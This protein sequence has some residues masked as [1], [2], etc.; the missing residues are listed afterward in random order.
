MA[1]LLRKGTYVRVTMYDINGTGRL[2][3]IVTG[4]L[5]SD[6]AT[7]ENGDPVLTLATRSGTE[8]LPRS[9][10]YIGLIERSIHTFSGR[11]NRDAGAVRS[12][13]SSEDT[14]YAFSEAASNVWSSS[15]AS[16]DRTSQAPSTQSSTRGRFKQPRVV[17]QTLQ[18]GWVVKVT[19]RHH[20]DDTA[21]AVIVSGRV[22]EVV[23][24]RKPIIKLLR[25]D[26]S[27]VLVPREQFL[28]SNI[29]LSDLE[30]FNVV[31]AGRSFK[32][33]QPLLRKS[34]GMSEVGGGSFVRMS[35]SRTNR[36][37]SGDRQTSLSSNHS[38]LDYIQK[39]NSMKLQLDNLCTALESSFNSVGTFNRGN[40][41]V[42]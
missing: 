3:T 14:R 41:S 2:P 40:V 10:L 37:S 9:R 31:G 18:P 24:M 33:D 29:D 13:T 34:P 5:T 20:S 35:R 23:D 42:T 36:K 22:I 30:G 26:G 15:Y 21:P 39:I 6:P 7:N 17:A 38:Y 28:I 4:A 19:M 1:K 32:S 11:L 25:D 8:T 27:A 12:T 16:N